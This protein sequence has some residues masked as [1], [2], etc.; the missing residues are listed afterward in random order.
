MYGSYVLSISTAA[1]R[2]HQGNLW[3]QSRQKWVNVIHNTYY[4]LS[5]YWYYTTNH[6]WHNLLPIHCTCLIL[7]C[8]VHACM[9]TRITITAHCR[10]G[11]VSCFTLSMR[12]TNTTKYFNHNLILT[13]FSLVTCPCWQIFV[14]STCIQF[15]PLGSYT[16]PMDT[17]QPQV[18]EVC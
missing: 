18:I 9:G 17:R 16:Y 7:T 13:D 12:Y 8:F 5:K 4:I 15:T 10:Q 6:H 1:F 11:T 14:L 2:V 3:T